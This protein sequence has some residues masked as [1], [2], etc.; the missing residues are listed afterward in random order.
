MD[1]STPGFPV[2]HYLPEFVQL[3]SFE[4]MMPSNYLILCPSLLLPSVLPS[5]RVFCSE[6][7]LCIRWPKIR[8]F[9]FIIRSSNEYLQL[10]WL[11][12]SPWSRKD[13]QES[14]S[15]PQFKSINSSHSNCHIHTW[16]LDKPQ[17]WLYAPLSAKWCLRFLIC[18]LGWS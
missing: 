13:S 7:A 6:S 10:I 14:F 8:S 9:S 15:T 17:L 5:T 11:V 3:I 2:L 4:S 16:L 12:W 1:S 18:C